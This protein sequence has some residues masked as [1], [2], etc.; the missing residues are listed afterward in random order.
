MKNMKQFYIENIK[1]YLNK[2][3]PCFYSFF[4]NG[5]NIHHDYS[6]Y[7]VMSVFLDENDNIMVEVVGYNSFALSYFN[8]EELSTQTLKMIYNKL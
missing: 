7:E 6:K 2:I 5:V 1:G 4:G 3:F 8:A